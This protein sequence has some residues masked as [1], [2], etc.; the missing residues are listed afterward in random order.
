MLDKAKEY[1]ERMV[2]AA[3][4]ADDELM[5]KFFEDGDLSE[6]DIIKGIKKGCL[7]MSITPM[8]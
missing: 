7:S 1:R 5:E 4:E 3:A 6:D 8:T 2:E